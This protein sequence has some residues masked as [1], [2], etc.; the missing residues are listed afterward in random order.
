MSYN[1]RVEEIHMM[2]LNRIETP[3]GT[4]LTSRHRHD[5]QSHVDTIT[6]ETYII[7]GGNDYKRYSINKVQAK[8]LSI[9]NDMP[10]EVIRQNFEWGT[11]GKD[12]KQPLR[13]V[14]L[15]DLDISHIRAILS[16]QMD[17]KNK[18]VEIFLEEIEY[19]RLYCENE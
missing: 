17:L 4:I 10:F 13:Y 12:G 11:R 1:N 18:L 5:Y 14:K 16:T 19:R 2:L 6:G 15:K 7:D 3:D 9:T 8:D